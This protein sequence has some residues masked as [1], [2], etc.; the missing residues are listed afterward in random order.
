M[1]MKNLENYKVSSEEHFIRKSKTEA[2]GKELKASLENF[3]A[4]QISKLEVMVE[5]PDSICLASNPKWANMQLCTINTVE[6][7]GCIAFV[8][9]IV[10]D[11]FDIP[12][13]MLDLIKLIEE[14]G[15]RICELSACKPIGIC[16][17]S[18][19]LDNLLKEIFVYDIDIYNNTRIHSFEQLISN[20]KEGFPIPMRVEN[21]IYYNDPQKI[22]GHYVVLYGFHDGLAYVADSSCPNGFYL[23]P[24][25]RLV[26]SM[27]GE[28]NYI[29]T[30]WN[31][32]LF[33]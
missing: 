32:N 3:D 15:Y 33:I 23:L 17:S 21:S 22:G 2:A 26:K 4:F 28:A 24:S 19:F 10:L 11:F 31:L 8:S 5:L 13:P 20:L 27:I 29:P 7:S 16:G 25:G 1:M 12:F 18:Y 9:K 30:A 14:K 6:T